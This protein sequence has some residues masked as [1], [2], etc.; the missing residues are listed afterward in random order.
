MSLTIVSVKNISFR[1]EEGT[2]GLDSV[3][4]FVKRGEFV[5]VLA[6][7]GGG[8]T[9]LLKILSG[10]LAPQK[11][12]VEINSKNIRDIPQK[13]L[14][15]MLGVVFQNPN[16]QLFEATVREDVAFGP[17]NIGL[18]REE[19]N[20]RI[21]KSLEDV[22][23]LH[24]IDRPIH[25][26][27]YGE[28]KR[29]CVAGVLAMNPEILILDEP[30]SGL[31]PKGEHLMLDILNKLN[32]EQYIT[33]IMATHSVD[34]LPLFADKIYILHKGK[35]LRSGNTRDVLTDQVIL[36]KANLRLPYVSRLL[37]EL[38]RLDGIP[39]SHLPLTIKEARER[40]LKLLPENIT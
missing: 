32:R 25:H 38:Q 22:E 35:V 10:L 24:L 21:E 3:D 5:S 4:F 26:L 9:T 29:V 39:A 28:Q 11:G 36:E 18:S 6:S 34:M 33:V 16:D 23:A 40:I 37:D 17:A 7:N 8:K 13:V 20:K 12:T 2:I 15:Q 14:Y 27:S 31:D 30:T 1:Y 19:I